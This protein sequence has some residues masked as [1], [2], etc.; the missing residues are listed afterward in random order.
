MAV[1]VALCEGLA[2]FG[3]SCRLKWPNDILLAGKKLGG[4]LLQTRGAGAAPAVVVS[5]G[6][7]LRHRQENLPRA[8]ATSL[9]LAL[10]PQAPQLA[11]LSA[12]LA[13]SVERRL[14][15]L[16]EAAPSVVADLTVS[17]RELSAHQVGDQL[18]VSAGDELLGGRFAGFAEDGRL[19]LA[20]TSGERLLSAEEIAP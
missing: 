19:R 6:V 8:D 12:A 1:G 9:R 5:F 10:G 3:A 14:T 13:Q 20:M 16:V 18:T 17:Y 2:G 4:V 15:S 7:N 11:A